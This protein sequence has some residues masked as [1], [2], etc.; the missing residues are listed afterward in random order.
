MC[1]E[2]HDE[3]NDFG[4]WL[5]FGIGSIQIDADEIIFEKD[6]FGGDRFDGY[7]SYRDRIKLNTVII[8]GC[9]STDNVF[10][11]TRTFDICSAAVVYGI[12]ASQLSCYLTNAGWG[13]PVVRRL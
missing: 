4:G 11:T 9:I 2:G 13:N 10:S 6:S 3:A 1:R 5:S 12:W 8:G 7:D